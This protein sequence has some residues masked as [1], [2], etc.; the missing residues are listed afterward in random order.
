[1]TDVSF[2]SLA[3]PNPIPQHNPIQY[4]AYCCLGLMFLLS[5]SQSQTQF[6]NTTLYSTQPTAVSFVSLA[7][8]NPIPQ[9]NPIQYTA[10]CCFLLM[11]LLSLTQSQ[12][13][14][15]NTTLYSTQP[16]AVSFVSLA[17]PNP[18][19][20]HNPIQYTAYCCLG[21]MFLLSLSQSQTQ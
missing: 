8:P 7:V 15:Q 21:L 6:Q 13:Q 2:V 1:M 4:T 12:T 11:F 9:H 20:Q 10:Y 14:F 3:V 5:L 16:T 17:V 18:I 19:P